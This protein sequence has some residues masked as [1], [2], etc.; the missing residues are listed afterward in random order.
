MRFAHLSSSEAF[1]TLTVSSRNVLEAQYAVEVRRRE[2]QCHS[3]PRH[4]RQN[5]LEIHGFAE[6]ARPWARNHKE[7]VEALYVEYPIPAT[8]DT[9]APQFV[10]RYSSVCCKDSA[11]AVSIGSRLQKFFCCAVS[12]A[13]LV[14]RAASTQWAEVKRSGVLVQKID[15]P[16]KGLAYSSGSN[17]N[18]AVQAALPSSNV[19]ISIPSGRMVSSASVIAQGRRRR[20][21]IAQKPAHERKTESNPALKAAI[22]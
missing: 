14:C 15:H 8:G 12:K 7:Y 5:R 11:T 20:W 10:V 22:G 19:D 9:F 6:S 16:P 21:H 2:E 18:R 17:L 3:C 13:P 1:Q 4:T